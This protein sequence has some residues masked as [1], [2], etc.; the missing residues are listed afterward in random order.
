MKKIP[1]FYA[2]F[3]AILMALSATSY[4]ADSEEIVLLEYNATDGYYINMPANGTKTLNYDQWQYADDWILKIV[5]G[6]GETSN[7]TTTTR[8]DRIERRRL[9]S[10]GRVFCED[11]GTDVVKMD[12]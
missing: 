8:T 10:Q 2:L 3:T 1:G 12:F 5:P 4:A 9:V 6:E 11:L 7:T